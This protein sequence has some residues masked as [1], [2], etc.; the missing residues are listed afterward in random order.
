MRQALTAGLLVAACLQSAAVAGDWRGE[1]SA[2]MRQFFASPVDP[3]QHD[4]FLSVSG[5]IEF[6]DEWDDGRHSLTVRPFARV[7]QHD[8]QRTHAD[9]RE[10]VWI[11]HNDGLEIRAGVDKVFWGVTEVYHLVDII[12]QTDLVE[13]PDGEQKLGQP[14]LKMSRESEFG[15]FDLYLLPWF[16][17]R[18]FPG[19][20]GRLRTQPRVAE[21]LSSFTSDR[22]ERHVD[23]A[24]RWSKNLGDWDL[25]VAH[26]R[27]TGRAPRL[28]PGIDASGL[29]VLKPRYEIIHQTSID[30]QGAVESWLWKFEGLRRSDSLDEF[31]AATGGFEYTLYG[32]GEGN[33]DIGILAEG[34][35]DE[36]GDSATTPFNHDAFV[37]VRWVANDVD[38]TE[39]LAGVVADWDNGS[40]FYNV[41]ASR[42]IGND[43]KVGIQARAWDRVDATD[44]LYPLRRDDYVELK[45]TKFF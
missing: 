23:L 28:L 41:E 43:V 13:N 36:R 24:A 32:F 31:F 4:R 1:V 19:A 44:A 40:R 27:G 20:E 15:T 16:R 3:V 25:G 38:G 10:A 22:G 39:L 34:M 8:E 29:P 45:L 33:S 30:L 26:F 11:Y 35:W 7:D 42:R 6:H 9:L 17:E 12:N 21:E 5:E 14:M 2:E 37:G 18:L